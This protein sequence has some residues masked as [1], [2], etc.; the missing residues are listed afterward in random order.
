M[1]SS[2]F[3]ARFQAWA[4]RVR[5]RHALRLSLTGAALGCV[6]GAAGAFG[7]WKAR[8]GPERPWTGTAALVGAV[9]GVAAARRRRMSDGEVALYLDGRLGTGEVIATALELRS[10][11]DATAGES[12]RAHVIAKASEALASAE[13][14]RAR[15]PVLAPLHAAVP[16]G[17]LALVYA[18]LLPLPP[19]PA[20]VPPPGSD[21]V[22]LAEVAGLEKVAE[23]AALNARDEEQKKRLEKIAKD[24]AALRE[25][26]REGVERREALSEIA[27]LQD[28]IAAER[29]ALGDGERRQ[30]MEAALSRLAQDPLTKDAA[31]ALG[32]RDL[33]RF[34]EEMQ[35]IAN[36]R[37]KADRERA[38]KA[39]AEAAEAAKKAGAA[40]VG[41]ALDAQRDLMDKR[42]ARADELRELAKA[43]EGSLTEEQK[44]DLE[45]F[46]G[47]GGP[48][49]DKDAAKM[50]KAMEDALKKLTPE[51]RKRLAENMK[52]R[53]AQQGSD[54]APPARQRLSDA[55]KDLDTEEGKKRLEEELRRLANEK[56]DDD[57]A[58]RQ[59]GLDGAQKGLGEA[60]KQL[61]GA[62]MPLPGSGD[63]KPG[64]KDGK[65]GKDGKPGDGKPGSG[66]DGKDGKDGP[67]KG[68]TE[69]KGTGDHKGQSKDVKGDELRAR[70]NAKVDGKAPTAG[71]T[72]GRTGGR[73]GDTA[74]V[75]GSG[76]IGQVGPSETSGVDKSEVP[77]EYRE[78][79][80]RY[81]QP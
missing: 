76:A 43:L 41:K 12:V 42:G 59:Q 81:F 5:A 20:A 64:G 22:T 74:N 13:P 19:A 73:A 39:L 51:E 58:K 40:D 61:G 78:Q 68:G 49:S 32:D 11:S 70:A 24:A 38:K 55:T 56:D 7:L 6:L 50:S 27:Q 80:G 66:K 71:I 77:E 23:L 8:K 14:K 52:K 35:K 45:E 21:K 1:S 2:D 36:T 28:A 30:G 63:G 79:V 65:D 60:Q 25:K 34:D 3:D 75:R 26:L 62:P 33:V 4:S 46:G 29:L 47:Q 44:R 53:L 17:A 31:K 69:D 18:S 48:K 54:I 16:V 57:E 67:G 72:I 15:P 9:V 10:T 37:E